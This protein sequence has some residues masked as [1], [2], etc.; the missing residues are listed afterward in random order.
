VDF[1][2]LINAI[3]RQTTVL[4]AQLATTAGIRAPLAHVANQVFL[5]LVR[6][7][8]GQG[9]GRKVVADM[10]GIALRSYQRKVQRLAESRTDRSK[11]L[12]SAALSFITDERVVARRRVLER[13]YHDDEEVLRAV[14]RDLIDSGLVYRTGRG[15]DSVYRAATAAEIGQATAGNAA[16]S[17]EAFVHM[18]V[19]HLAPAS[20]Q[21]ICEET[22]LE[23]ADVL[24]ALQD[25][26]A[27]GRIEALPLD[28]EGVP[29]WRCATCLLPADGAA[30]WE[31]ALFH[32]Y[33][34]VVVAICNKLQGGRTRSLPKDVIGGSTWEYLVWSG[35]PFESQVMALLQETR[36][37]A[38][39]LRQ[40][41]TAHNERHGRPED[42]T[43]VIFYTGQTVHLGDEH[44]E[45]GES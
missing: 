23:P 9:L 21:T 4:I 6:E 44:I 34:S 26:V 20:V 45:E 2:A 35:H 14:L 18:A 13:F 28:A 22:R 17:T 25:L 10:F 11:T 3:V 41:V 38:S 40:A 36:A 37:R 19:Y 15:D 1:Q 7:L 16:T 33:Q 29:S 31:A 43:R 5:D 42:A 39:A 32:H 27:D 8:E 24:R 12:W 30:G